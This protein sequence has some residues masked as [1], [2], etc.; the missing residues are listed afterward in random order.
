M[1]WVGGRS[2][3]YFGRKKYRT[4]CALGIRRW[5]SENII[6]KNYSW[7]SGS[8]NLVDKIRGLFKAQEQLK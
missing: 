6:F 1:R 2:E 8:E 3:S 4:W 5:W 7:V